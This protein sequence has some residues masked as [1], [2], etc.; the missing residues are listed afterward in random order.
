MKK[1]GKFGK[2]WSAFTYLGLAILGMA[3]MFL[4]LAWSMYVQ[5]CMPGVIC[6]QVVP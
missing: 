4:A 5:G 1:N 6:V 2:V 3:L